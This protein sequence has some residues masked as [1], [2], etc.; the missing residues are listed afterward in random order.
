M[1]GG[2]SVERYMVV[3]VKGLPARDVQWGNARRLKVEHTYR[4]ED[5]CC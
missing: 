3:H 1:Y 4:N 2:M 5:G